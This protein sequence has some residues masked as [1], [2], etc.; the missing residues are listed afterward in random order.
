MCFKKVCFL[1]KEN[2]AIL[3]FNL[4]YALFSVH[5]TW[6][7][8]DNYNC[9]KFSTILKQANDY[10][11]FCCKLSIIYQNILLYTIVMFY[12]LITI[13]YCHVCKII[14]NNEVSLMKTHSLG[15]SINRNDIDLFQ[16]VNQAPQV[17]TVPWPV[18]LDTMDFF[19]V[20]HA[21]V[22]LKCFVIL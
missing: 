11:L 15:L 22:P 13:A 3:F 21:F 18:S 8:I 20:N 17:K 7:Y 16:S 10:K 14:W 12:L 4:L 9:L 2:Q 1:L 5:Y 19:A 6:W